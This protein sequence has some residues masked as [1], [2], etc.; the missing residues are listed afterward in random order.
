MKKIVIGFV[1]VLLS[2]YQ[3]V[4]QSE[5]KTDTIAWFHLGNYDTCFVCVQQIGEEYDVTDCNLIIFQVKDRDTIATKFTIHPEFGKQ[6]NIYGDGDNL[7]VEDGF[8]GTGH[9]ATYNT[10]KEIYNYNAVLNAWV[11]IGN[12]D[13]SYVFTVPGL[14]EN[15]VS[16][17]DMRHTF[18]GD[19]LIVDEQKLLTIQKQIEIQLKKE[20][21]ILIKHDKYCSFKILDSYNIYKIMKYLTFLPSNDECYGNLKIL[22]DYLY[23][24][25]SY[26]EAEFIYENLPASPSVNLQLGN[27]EWLHNKEYAIRYY[28]DY[29]IEDTIPSEKR[30]RINARVLE[31]KNQINNIMGCMEVIGKDCGMCWN[32][33]VLIAIECLEW[34]RDV[35]IENVVEYNNLAYYLLEYGLVNE[36]INLLNSVIKAFPNR[37]VAYINLGDAYWEADQNELAIKAYKK[38]VE[39]MEASNKAQLIPNRIKERLL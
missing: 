4:A 37:K 34:C 6:L 21:D 23:S 1:C 36:S 3:I 5:I 13:E 19:T 16:G 25:H 17:G 8:N 32:D 26:D 39:L 33:N 11:N 12:I 35:T 10:F 22:A 14:E 2:T 15:Y 18:F 24:A 31:T 30:S 7:V 9:Y 20:V 27:I 28:E 29:L 38:Y